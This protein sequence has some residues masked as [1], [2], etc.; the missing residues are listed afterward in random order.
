MRP[1]KDSGIEWIGEVPIDWRSAPLWALASAR[2]GGTPKSSEPS[3]WDDDGLPW[4]SIGD[5]SSVRKV[6]ATAKAVSKTG[7]D[8]KNIPVGRH[9]DVLFAMYASVG[10]VA[11][12]D[13]KACWNQAILGLRAKPHQVKNWY[14]YYLLKGLGDTWEL[15]SNAN[16]QANLNQQSTM[17][18]RLAVPPIDQQEEMIHYLDKETSKIDLLRAT[19]ESSIALLKER[20]QALITRAVTGKLDVR[21]GVS[22]GNS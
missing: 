16:T 10:A 14:L 17:H 20:R 21:G 7:L 6:Q 2:A 4:I 5:M 18:L 3:Y 8:S 22:D 1:M 11:M 13:I 15:L 19:A 12:L 9:G